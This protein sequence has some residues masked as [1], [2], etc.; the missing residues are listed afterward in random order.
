MKRT[1]L[2]ILSMALLLSACGNHA[3]SQNKP[4]TPTWQE[5]YDLGV[6]YLSEGNYEEAIIAFTAAIEINPKQVP[7]YVGRGD[8]Y[9]LS[10]ETEENLTA[11]KSDYEKAIELDETCA[12]AYLGLADVYIRQ[13]DYDKALKIL[14][15][16]LEKIGENQEIPEKIKE[17]D[18]GNITDSSGNVRRMTSYD[19]AGMVLFWHDYAYNT[20]GQRDS[21]TSF[22]ATGN[23]TGHVNLTY[24]EAGETLTTY[25]YRST[26]EVGQMENIYDNSGN[27]ITI[28]LYNSDGTLGSTRT[29][30]YNSVGQ[31]IRCDWAYPDGGNRYDLYEYDSQG[32]ETKCSNYAEDGSL[33]SY[34]ITVYN[35]NDQRAGYQWYS[36]SGEL[37]WYV[38]DCYDK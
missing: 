8:A 37:Q 23:Q 11:A 25:W 29:Y 6:R 14:K 16:G 34:T 3:D 17:I 33:D 10:G 32:R 19:A 15:Q 21:V 30:T 27:L 35:E 38:V 9:V 18:A 20:Q 4:D 24:N 5:Q 26:G 31:Q 22:D 13:G 1:L 12:D 2:C 28:V 36:G 7:A